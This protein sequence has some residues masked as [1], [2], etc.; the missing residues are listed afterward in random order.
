M[1]DDLFLDQREIR[2]SNRQTADTSE[3]AQRELAQEKKPLG[4]SY[5]TASMGR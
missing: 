3:P 1:T 2:C 5:G 4:P